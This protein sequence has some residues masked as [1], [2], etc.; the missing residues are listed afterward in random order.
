M[1]MCYSGDASPMREL[2][3]IAVKAA[4]TLDALRLGKVPSERAVATLV[5]QELHAV[6]YNIQSCNPTMIVV[7]H[8][9]YVAW[10][11]NRLRTVYDLSQKIGEVSRRLLLA[12]HRPNTTS[13]EEAAL[14]RDFCTELSKRALAR[15]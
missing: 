4:A 1:T 10:S 15:A 6:A 7:T 14:L 5:T 8:D 9:A 11:G 13:D 12:C 2:A 3:E